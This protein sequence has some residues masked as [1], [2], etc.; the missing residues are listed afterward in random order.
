MSR[1][2]VLWLLEQGHKPAHLRPGMGDPLM[3]ALEEAIA[4]REQGQSELS[5]KLLERLEASGMSNP[6]II[7][8]KA[9]A[10]L[11]QG[12]PEAACAYWRELE[13]HSDRQAS[14][15]ATQMIQQVQ[16]QLLEGLHLHCRFHSWQPRYLP[17]V[18]QGT[19]GD[20]THL[21]L[22][23]AIASLEA[24]KAGLSLALMEEALQQGWRN[25]WLHDNR[26]RALVNLGRAD[27]ALAVWEQLCVEHRD[28]ALAQLAVE[29]IAE[30]HEQQR[31][32]QLK[33]EACEQLE[34]HQAPAAETLLLQAWLLKPDDSDL[35]QLL[36]QAVAMQNSA[37]GEDILEQELAEVNK[38]LA[39]QE[40]LQRYLEERLTPAL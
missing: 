37:G 20:L 34:R 3:P 21:A 31:V 16:Q 30:L 11:F 12:Q 39:V 17:S 8:N 27:E 10:L 4:L 24:N 18:D 22:K 28:S 40:R 9:R 29:A 38:Q 14:T 35:I 1:E 15:T 25:P 6:W 32:E 7:D 5:L 23:E 26:A 13:G 2:L 19:P 33:Q 36:E